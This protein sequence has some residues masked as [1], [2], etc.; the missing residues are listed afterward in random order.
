MQVTTAM[1]ADAARVESGKLFIHGGGWDAITVPSLPVTQPTLALVLV[2][3]VD[4][5]EAHQ[6]IPF[7][8]E[9]LD[10]DD[11]PI[12]PRIDGS[13]SV[14]QTPGTRPG[15]PTFASHALTFNLLTFQQAGGYR[16]RVTSEG[17]ELASVPFTISVAAA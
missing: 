3:R 11:H 12:G 16:F 4:S 5:S 13:L 14:G 1:L 2:L 15:T 8:V 10:E 9:L 17:T 6:P 7:A